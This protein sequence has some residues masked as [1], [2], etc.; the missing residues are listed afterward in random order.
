MAS[1]TQTLSGMLK[2]LREAK[3]AQEKCIALTYIRSNTSILELTDVLDEEDKNSEICS[4]I[5]DAF[6]SDD[7][8]VH[9]EAYITLML[10]FVRL[11]IIV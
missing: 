10:F 4:L 11:K 8:I 9:H 2:M 7:Q 5:I 1:S 3:N 6:I